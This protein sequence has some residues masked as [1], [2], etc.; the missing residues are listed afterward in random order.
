MSRDFYIGAT[1]TGNLNSPSYPVTSGETDVPKMIL[2]VPMA[3]GNYIEA[4]LTLQTTTN[5][6]VGVFGSAINGS[7]W[8]WTVATAGAQISSARYTPSITYV[9]YGNNSGS[10]GSFTSYE[11]IIPYNTYVANYALN[12]Q[13]IRTGDAIYL[14]IATGDGSHGPYSLYKD[15]GEST[16]QFFVYSGVDPGGIPTF[17]IQN[18]AGNYT[19]AVSNFFTNAEGAFWQDFTNCQETF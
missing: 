5:N 8:D 12:L 18:N 15:L 10:G 2:S 3:D 7:S 6:P 14:T 16:R 9:A 11:C 1:L 13:L 19:A 4:Y 17:T